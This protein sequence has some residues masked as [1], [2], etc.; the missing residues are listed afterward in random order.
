MSTHRI[1]AAQ[2]ALIALALAAPAPAQTFTITVTTT[3]DTGAGSLRQAI[4]AANA[5]GGAASII[6]NVPGGGTILLA[7][8][9]RESGKEWPSA[10]SNVL[11]PHA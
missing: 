2:A 7:R 6:F 9:I 1:A 11:N 8:I 4:A 3:A 5:A 10:A